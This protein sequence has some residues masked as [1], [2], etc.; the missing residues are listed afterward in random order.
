LK[1]VAKKVRILK[2]SIDEYLEKAASLKDEYEGQ[3]NVLA[4]H[5]TDMGMQK[6]EFKGVGLFY[7]SKVGHVKPTVPVLT[8]ADK[9]VEVLGLKE[10]VKEISEEL[11]RDSELRSRIATKLAC[12]L[13]SETIKDSDLKSWFNEVL[14]QDEELAKKFDPVLN[15]YVEDR[16][17]IRKPKGGSDE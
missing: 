2:D 16:L 10:K 1:A 7:M 5:M 15:V 9:F 12:D 13:I 8:F 6:Y 17:N 14:E 4:K 11:L 3:R